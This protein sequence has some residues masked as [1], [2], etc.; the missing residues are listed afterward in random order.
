MS[1]LSILIERQIKEIV[2]KSDLKEVKLMKSK[3]LSKD[4][5]F[6]IIINPKSKLALVASLHIRRIYPLGCV[7]STRIFH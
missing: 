2:T 5:V 1:D 4:R 7:V 3:S 6:R